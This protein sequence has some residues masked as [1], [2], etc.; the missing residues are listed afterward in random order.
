MELYSVFT[1]NFLTVY[2]HEI[3][4]TLSKH[5]QF[6]PQ[7]GV[8]LVKLKHPDAEE[9]TIVVKETELVIHTCGETFTFLE[10]K[11]A[12]ELA[13]KTTWFMRNA[14]E[15]VCEVSKQFFEVEGV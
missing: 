13:I 6:L 9:I 10:L 2:G 4:F 11:E 8:L 1:D 14:S 12:L 15:F 7:E 5:M 3:L